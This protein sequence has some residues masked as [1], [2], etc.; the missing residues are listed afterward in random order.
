MWSMN[1]KVIFSAIISIGILGTLLLF[2]G[3]FS[4]SSIPPYVLN[5]NDLPDKFTLDKTKMIN[6]TIYTQ[7]WNVSSSGLILYVYK[8]SNDKDISDDWISFHSNESNFYE[9]IDYK[10]ASSGVVNKLGENTFLFSAKIGLFV[11]SC[12]SVY[13]MKNECTLV[14]ES[15]IAKLALFLEL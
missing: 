5:E 6:E 11:V 7:Y 4:G 15:Q 13:S 10:G 9:E 12:F 14:I 2:V 3:L 8:Y 1:N